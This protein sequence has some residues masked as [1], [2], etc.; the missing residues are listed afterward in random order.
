MSTPRG[1]DMFGSTCSRKRK[2]TNR[3]S[4]IA[5]TTPATNTSRLPRLMLISPAVNSWVTMASRVE[6]TGRYT[7]KRLVV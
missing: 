2:R 3:A 4:Q 6:Y 7:R 5:S 1:N